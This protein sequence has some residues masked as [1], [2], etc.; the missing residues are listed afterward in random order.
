VPKISLKPLTTIQ[1]SFALLCLL[2]L[3]GTQA[4]IMPLLHV[5]G[6]HTITVSNAQTIDINE[7]ISGDA[8]SI[9]NI[10]GYGRVDLHAHSNNY[11]GKVVIRGAEFR[12]TWTGRMVDPQSITVENGGVFI[13]D[14]NG[15]DEINHLSEDSDI[16]LS[17]G[18]VRMIGRST[19][20]AGNSGEDF[21]SL[22]LQSG[23]NVVDIQNIHVGVHTDLTPVK[24]FHRKGIST[25]NLIGN[26]KYVSS[27]Q[28]NRVS[29]RSPNW[30]AEGGLDRGGIVP[31]ATVEGADWATRI[32]VGTTDYLLALTIYRTSTQT[33]WR[34]AHNVHLS[35]NDSLTGSRVIN[36]LKIGNANLNLGGYTLTID[37]GGLLSVGTDARLS[38][39]GTVIVGA[40]DRPLYIHVYGDTLSL[41]DETVFAG[42]SD[43]VKTGPGTLELESNTTHELGNIII[44]QGAIKLLKGAVS[45]SGDIIV[46]DG[47]GQDLFELA[48][49]SD[50]R[51]TKTGGGL[52]SMTLHGNPYGPATDEA[53]LRFN[54]N[55][56]Q[57]LAELNIRNRGTLDFLG[58]TKAT[59]NILYL[60]QLNFSDT[61][62]RLIIRN[63]ND[64]A[65]YL[66]VRK[67]WGD[68]NVAPILNQIH[69]E[70][71]G[72]AKWHWHDLGSSYSD[73]W[74]ITPLPEPATTSAILGAVGVAFVAWRK[75]KM[76]RKS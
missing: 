8:D 14:N 69:F 48:A 7:A 67:I 73:Y 19:G 61:N 16:I 21:G 45:V 43:L 4:Q 30:T 75:R 28:L 5:D 44:H 50:N 55:S 34:I 56:R 63:W 35:R 46:G 66:L 18:T 1:I 54:G 53:I 17:G 40:A 64:Q 9:L 59:P 26:V 29:L 52:P 13:M 37:A 76:H 10:V 36:S 47:A 20:G 42:S 31:W 74:Q 58:S 49:Q 57:A 70:G 51:I 25:L 33:T 22:I 68:A 3:S 2:F 11:L 60:D 38:G 24:G 23:A 71:Y 41:E 32:K 62:A 39:P 6:T 72:P 12:T 15:G 27:N 65:D